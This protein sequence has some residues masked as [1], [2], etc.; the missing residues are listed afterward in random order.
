MILLGEEC[1]LWSFSLCSFLQLPIT[2]SLLGRNILLSILFSTTLSLCSS[3]NVRDQVSDPYRVTG[4]IIVLC[5]LILMFLD[6]RGELLRYNN[7]YLGKRRFGGVY[8]MYLQGLEEKLKY[9]SA[10]RL[11]VAS[12]LLRFLLKIEELICSS[13]TSV[14]LQPTWL[15]NPEGHTYHSGIFSLTW[16]CLE[17]GG[18]EVRKGSRREVENGKS[19]KK[20]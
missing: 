20:W 11:H 7:M 3:L 18:K 14:C 12:F 4:K 16:T 2:S 19:W 5:V 15:C 6:S 8:R 17:K 9:G 10:C 13:E 1:K